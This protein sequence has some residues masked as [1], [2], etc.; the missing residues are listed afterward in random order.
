MTMADV[1]K[2]QTS[3]ISV[4]SAIVFS[5]TRSLQTHGTLMH[6]KTLQVEGCGTQRCQWFAK[7]QKKYLH[8]ERYSP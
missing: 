5:P 6:F 4:H 7:L 2:K 8:S 1:K 3:I